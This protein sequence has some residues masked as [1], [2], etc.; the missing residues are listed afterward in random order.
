VTVASRLKIRASIR[1]R[2]LSK[3]LGKLRKSHLM[4]GHQAIAL[5][6]Q[7]LVSGT[8]FFTALLI[9]RWGG[10]AELGIY[11]VILATLLTI[12]S[13]QN[14]LVVVPYSIQ[15]HSPVGTPDE[16]AGSLMIFSVALGGGTALAVGLIGLVIL[17]GTDQTH[18]AAATFVLAAALPFTLLRE[19]S[20]FHLFAHLQVHRA[21]LLD[22]LFAS[23]QLGGLVLLGHANG[24]S[25]ITA[26]GLL[27]F[28]S[29]L[30]VLAWIFLTR[31]TIAFNQKHLYETLRR[32]WGLGGWLLV[33][34]MLMQVQRY[35]PYWLVIV[36]AGAELTG[37][38]AAC[39]SVV[40]FSNPIVFG[41][42]NVLI[43]RAMQALKSKGRLGLREQ[44][45]RDALL[46][47]LVTSLFGGIVFVAGEPILAVF[48]IDL[49]LAS[50]NQLL[51][52]LVAASFMAAVGMPAANG[53][54]SIEQPRSEVK[55]GVAA[56][57]TTIALCAILMPLFGLTGVA[58]GLL[59]GTSIA[60]IGRWT[61]LL[62][63]CSPQFDSIRAGTPV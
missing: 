59:I 11:S 54:A 1:I 4:A 3:E 38:Y 61:T 29:C 7:A 16:H 53:L 44:A 21:L 52:V 63:L 60:S 2:C 43:P 32:T 55:I 37:I 12:F 23:S 34:Q 14:A 41:L 22:I 15:H 10:T 40:A 49:N 26:V 35:A 9:A 30:A 17:L 51:L 20:R 62:R 24:V 18:L 48:K 25:A 42:G 46:L 27:A 45:A 8:N 47:G 28:A 33:N 36:L 31:E 39:M 6:D 19:F 5:I 50:A 56:A 57:A 13:I 58:Y